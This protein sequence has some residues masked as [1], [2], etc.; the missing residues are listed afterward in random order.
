MFLGKL[1]IFTGTLFFCTNIKYIRYIIMELKVQIPDQLSEITITQYSAYLNI[2]EQFE[3][4]KEQN[5]NSDVFYLLKTLEI[6]TG[7][8]YQDGMKLRLTDVKKIILKIEK[9]LSEKP[10]LIRSFK[11]GDTTFGFIPKLDDMTFGEY[12]DLDTNISNWDNMHKA[13]AVLYR[14]I[15]LKK[16]GLYLIE[17]YKGDA[18]HE[19]MKLMPLDV[20]FSS[21]IFF[22]HLGMDLSIG[23]TKFLEKAKA[24]PEL[25]ESQ[26]F[27]ENGDGINQSILSLK[28]MLQDMKL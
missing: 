19:A 22:Y 14:P 2:I 16:K 21:L 17:D 6:F 7:I 18:Y 25:M 13:M 11:L 9:L 20:A 3:K 27:L 4:M 26:I 8:N 5:K 15:K 23:M 24:K 10:E 28:G 12:V 1:G